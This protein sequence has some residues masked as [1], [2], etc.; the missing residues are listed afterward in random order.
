MSYNPNKAFEVDSNGVKIENGVLIISGSVDPVSISMSVP[1]FYHRTNGEIW[2]HA[3]TGVWTLI[4]SQSLIFNEDIILTNY[5]GEVI[6]D[7]Y[8]NV[9]RGT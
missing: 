2:W 8:Y 7:Q 1:A 6:T 5:Q 9:L 4:S 3:G